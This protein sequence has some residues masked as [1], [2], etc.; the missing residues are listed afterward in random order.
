MG[1]K[2]KTKV[3]RSWRIRSLFIW[4]GTHYEIYKKLGSHIVKMEKNRVFILQYGL[5]M[6]KKFR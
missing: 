3:I 1:E 2:N 5:H 4:K 6:R